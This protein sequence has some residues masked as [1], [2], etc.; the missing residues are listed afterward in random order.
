MLRP[1]KTNLPN[2]RLCLAFIFLAAVAAA[3]PIQA[4]EELARKNACTACHA[5]DEKVVGPSFTDIARKYAG[6]EGAA[7]KVAEAIRKGGTGAWGSI[8]MPA[9]AQLSVDDARAL[10]SWILAGKPK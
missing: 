2:E 6:Q 7:G 5:A 10:A 3:S 8:P 9:Q 4:S 1:I